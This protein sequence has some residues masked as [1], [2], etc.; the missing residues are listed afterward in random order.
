MSEFGEKII[1]R[2]KDFCDL[3]NDPRAHVWAV[4]P[5]SPERFCVKCKRPYSEQTDD[6]PCSFNPEVN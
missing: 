1:K 4:T 5:L 3:M 6:L 2:L